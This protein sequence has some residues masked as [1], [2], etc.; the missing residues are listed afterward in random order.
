M[1]HSIKLNYRI[2]SIQERVLGFAYNDIILLWMYLVNDETN[3]TDI[4]S[5]IYYSKLEK[6][7]EKS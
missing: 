1:F 4:S 2:K 5:R 6:W 3:S 7:L